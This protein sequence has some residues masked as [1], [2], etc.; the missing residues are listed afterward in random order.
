MDDENRES[1]VR[2]HHDDYVVVYD[3]AHL[4]PEVV[5]LCPKCG[6]SIGTIRM[7]E[8]GRLLCANC[9]VL[10]SAEHDADAPVVTELRRVVMT[11]ASGLPSVGQVLNRP[12]IDISPTFKDRVF[13]LLWSLLMAGLLML[14][15]WAV[16]RYAP[17]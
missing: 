2:G 16:I 12:D 17:K 1:T 7:G 6:K 8:K 10:F 15:L 13:M 14:G 5:I 3:S 9:S 4:G 11:T